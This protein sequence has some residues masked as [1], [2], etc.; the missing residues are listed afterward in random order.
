MDFDAKQQGRRD[1]SPFTEKNDLDF[2]LYDAIFGPSDRPESVLSIDSVLNDPKSNEASH[3]NG[4]RPSESGL[5]HGSQASSSTIG[6]TPVYSFARGDLFD[7]SAL[8]HSQSQN[9]NLAAANPNS[10]P[11]RATPGHTHGTV[12]TPVGD[13]ATGT[14]EPTE[15]P[16]A[17]TLQSYS[18]TDLEDGL[19]CNFCF[20][21][22]RRREHRKANQIGR[23]LDFKGRS[24]PEIHAFARTL[25]H[26]HDYVRKNHKEHH[27]GPL[28][29]LGRVVSI[30]RLPVAPLVDEEERDDNVGGSWVDGSNAGGYEPSGF[31]AECD[32]EEN[33]N[34][35]G[36]PNDDE[37]GQ[38]VSS[39][40]YGSY[41][42]AF[43]TAL[44]QPGRSANIL[45]FKSLEAARKALRPDNI[46]VAPDP[47]IPKTQ[48]QKQALVRAL[49]SY[50]ISVKNAQDN[51]KAI[52]NFT[53]SLTTKRRRQELELMCWEILERSIER[54]KMGALGLN[55]TDKQFNG[56]FKERLTGIMQA[57]DKKKTICQSTCKT[58]YRQQLIDNPFDKMK[59]NHTNKVNNNRKKDKIKAGN[60][61]LKAQAQSSDAPA[62]DA[63]D[64]TQS[65]ENQTL[66]QNRT[67]MRTPRGQNNS[68]T[69]E[70]VPAQ[71]QNV[72]APDHHPSPL[73]ET[74]NIDGDADDQQGVLNHEGHQTS[75][76]GSPSQNQS[77]NSPQRATF[78]NSDNFG[79]QAQSEEF[80]DISDNMIDDFFGLTGPYPYEVPRNGDYQPFAPGPSMPSQLPYSHAPITNN[81]TLPQQMS[82]HNSGGQNV[83]A[84]NSVHG[85]MNQGYTSNTNV[86]ANAGQKGSHG[87]PM[88][89]ETGVRFGA[90]LGSANPLF[91]NDSE[92]DL[93]TRPNEN[94]LAQQ[95]NR[96][97]T[98]P[99][100]SQLFNARP[101]TPIRRPRDDSRAYSADQ[102]SQNGTNTR[103]SR[104][105]SRADNE[106][107]LVSTS[108]QAPKRR[109]NLPLATNHD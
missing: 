32:E 73:L 24:L 62:S 22:W 91:Q 86:H 78:A 1:T 83:H 100:T 65:E 9:I 106:D 82:D 27:R 10:S 109:R 11:A 44:V 61:V 57:F 71:L 19:K 70:Q 40:H 77:Q 15:Y 59:G 12:P 64:R 47:T 33:V 96:V 50:V 79:Q 72:N 90:M 104:K 23:P 75:A 46:R 99:K 16:S 31:T 49:Y 55:Q 93:A 60:E 41:E 38:G 66:Q 81:N 48:E 3:L 69:E 20:N 95:L 30:K 6:Q 108:S 101:Y 21:D 26:F 2:G 52:D 37:Q 107:A 53:K 88:D 14:Q 51:Q 63:G 67:R 13:V 89:L 18:E 97:A 29:Q 35:D 42:E 102:A 8:H 98:P 39:L 17:S 43:D 74:P 25:P 54:A 7:P 4:Y 92:P 84:A 45:S 5:M 68:R 103:T 94:I 34:F 58:G 76:A 28:E 87:L 85:S 56:C 105:R 80:L 36:F